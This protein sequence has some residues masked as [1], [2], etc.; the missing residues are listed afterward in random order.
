[1]ATSSEVILI[2][3]SYTEKP[4]GYCLVYLRQTTNFHFVQE[5]KLEISHLTYKSQ[6]C[7]AFCSK[8]SASV[9]LN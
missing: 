7:F 4:T 5:V 9:I 3:I 6:N 1:M 2:R 8:L